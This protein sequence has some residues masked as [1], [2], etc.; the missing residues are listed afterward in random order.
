MPLLMALANIVPFFTKYLGASDSVVGKIVDTAAGIASGI[1]GANSPQ[2]AIKMLGENAEM[3][4]AFTLKVTE[5]SIEWDKVYL[6][7][8]ADARK[9]DAE[10]LKAGARNYRADSM[11]L[12]SVFVV[13][14]L[15]Y[16]TIKDT[17]LN[18]YAKGII[19]LVLGRFLGY[20]DGIFNFEFGTTR[21]SR[22]K[23]ETINKLSSGS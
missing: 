12:L 11:Y 2:E 13:C 18:E 15:V 5:Q 6:N 21:T 8:V 20:L 14:V 22:S 9:R 4:N 7:D 16:Y 1:T 10:F 23:D 17:S 19:T 3:R